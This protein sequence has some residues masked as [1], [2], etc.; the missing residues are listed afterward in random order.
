MVIKY[1]R[2]LDAG[3]YHARLIDAYTT[4]TA[5]ATSGH[6]SSGQTHASL[7]HR[8]DYVF[9]AGC[10]K[11]WTNFYFKVHERRGH[12]EELEFFQPPHTV[13][14]ELELSSGQYVHLTSLPGL[15]MCSHTVGLTGGSGTITFD[16]YYY[17]SSS[18]KGHCYRVLIDT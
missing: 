13:T 4:I 5:H 7:I 1:G 17:T 6:A 2:G 15:P 10:N 16:I 11:E 8:W 9:N 12:G 14:Q 18:N 3:G